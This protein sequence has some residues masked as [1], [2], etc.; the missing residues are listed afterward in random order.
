MKENKTKI[1]T[2][3]DMTLQ[4]I[5]DLVHT[6]VTNDN[7]HRGAALIVIQDQKMRIVT[8][9]NNR[10]LSVGIV[11]AMLQDGAYRDAV[12]EAVKVYTEHADEI[13]AAIVSA[14]G[15]VQQDKVC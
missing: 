5:V 2:A 7:E 12:M 15:K 8:N 11:G 13:R 14:Q 10:A 9:C 1:A 6:W 4:D 3:K